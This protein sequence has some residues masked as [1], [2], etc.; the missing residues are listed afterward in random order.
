MFVTGASG[1]LGRH[2]V[3]LLR[4]RGDEVRALVRDPRRLEV[5]AGVT[6]VR[7]DLGDNTAIAEGI[8]GA[9]AVVHAAAVYEIGVGR[10]R[11][12]EMYEANVVGTQR[13]LGTARDLGVP[14]IVHI[15]TVA[16]FG[17]TQGLVVD[18]SYARPNRSFTSY[19]EE[20]KVRAHE[21]ARAVAEEGAPVVIVQPGQLYGPGDSSGFGVLL[22]AFARRRLPLVPFADLGLTMS[23]V[24][25]VAAGVVLAI[26]RGA[27]G[28]AYVMGGEIVR[29]RHVF[30][31]LAAALGRTPPRWALPYLP[32]QFA[33]LVVPRAAEL[34]RSAKGV[35][36]WARDARARTEL[37][38]TSRSLEEGLRATYTE[39]SSSSSS[40]SDSNSSE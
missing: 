10:S 7:G 15:S 29:V 20:T 11:R 8:R 3:R 31:T 27:P 2:V 30:G 6:V 17:N 1:F 25:D 21:I 37:G 12:R 33:A 22:R 14:K 24:E 16:V 4:E 32:L 40:S 5:D 38:Y 28:R 34:V 26:D 36:F 18:E 19:Y 35:T 9:D 13:V 23:H 39:G